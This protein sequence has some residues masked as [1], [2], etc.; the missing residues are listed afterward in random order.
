MIFIK[1]EFMS[2]EKVPKSQSEQF[3]D[4]FYD[5]KAEQEFLFHLIEQGIKDE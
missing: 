3:D 5:E 4:T 1:G 2:T